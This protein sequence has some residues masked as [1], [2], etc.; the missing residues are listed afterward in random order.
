MEVYSGGTMDLTGRTQVVPTWL[1]CCKNGTPPVKDGP[2]F[3]RDLPLSTIDRFFVMER[4]HARV[5]MT[6]YAVPFDRIS[7]LGS[8]DPKKKGDEMEDPNGEGKVAF[9][10]CYTRVRACLLSYLDTTNEI[11]GTPNFGMKPILGRK[12]R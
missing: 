4:E 1:T 2:T 3:V 8:F 10:L 5:L 7:S 6:D 12:R 11:P 9:D